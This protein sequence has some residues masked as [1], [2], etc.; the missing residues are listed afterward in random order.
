[1]VGGTT[2]AYLH[3]KKFFS[4]D[5]SLLPQSDIVFPGFW[6]NGTKLATLQD[7]EVPGTPDSSPNNTFP[8]TRLAQVTPLD[9]SVTY[10]YHQINSTTFSEEKYDYG[11]G[12]WLPSTYFTVADD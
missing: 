3:D 12:Q 7:F 1:M 8:F 10:L 5:Y 11:L 6:V 2:D 4:G 9:L